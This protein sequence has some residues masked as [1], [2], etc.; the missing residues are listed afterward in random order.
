MKNVLIN[1]TSLDAVG[2]LTILNQYTDNLAKKSEDDKEY[3]VFVPDACIIKELKSNIHYIKNS[4]NP[5]YKGRNY[6]NSIGMKKWCKNNRINPYEIFSMQNYYPFGFGNKKFFKRLYLHQSI[7]FFD[8]KWRLFK[9][10]ERVLWFYKNIY[11]F[12]IKWSVKKS[13]QVIV[14]TE[15]FKKQLVKI[16]NIDKEK[17]I[18][19]KPVLNKIDPKNYNKYTE[20]K[21]QLKLFYPASEFIYK[22]H[23]ILYKAMDIIVNEY[24]FKNIVLY[25]TLE[26]SNNY[27]LDFIKKYNLSDNIILTGILD[28]E[29]VMHYYKTVDVLVFPSKIETFGLPLIEAQYFNLPIIASDLELYREVIGNYSGDV[30]Y[31]K[32]DDARKWADS[33]IFLSVNDRSIMRHK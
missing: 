27:V 13:N 18:V 7:P 33:I 14:Q 31:C 32:Y 30:V 16:F 4:K 21:G 11:Y 25:L 23:E 3:Y 8:Y 20:L 10:E 5:S 22:N 1:A 12:L 9:K 29:Q 6:W 28:Y 15:W 19:E 24:N 2:A 26:D 17:I